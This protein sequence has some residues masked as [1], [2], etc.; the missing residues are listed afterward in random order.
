MPN[1]ALP[2]RQIVR[3]LYAGPIEAMTFHPAL[4]Y[5]NE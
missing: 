1:W 2:F 4:I 5:K 3:K